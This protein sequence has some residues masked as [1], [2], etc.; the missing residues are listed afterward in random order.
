MSKLQGK[1]LCISNILAGSR[2]S[3]E[4]AALLTEVD[5]GLLDKVIYAYALVVACYMV[6]KWLGHT[7]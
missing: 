6:S 3:A 4:R 7:V 2:A 5:M 1:V